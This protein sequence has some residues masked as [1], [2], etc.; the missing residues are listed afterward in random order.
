[1]VTEVGLED[2]LLAVV[3][4]QER[5]DLEK[6]RGTLLRQMNTMTIELQKC[7]DGLLYELTNATGD[8]LENVSLIENL[9]NTKKKAK[10]INIS[11]AQAVATQK[12]IAQSRLTYTPVAVR[13]SLLF[14]QIDQLWKIDHMYQYSLEAFM[15][16]FNKAL[17]KAV[18]PEDKK[19]VPKRVE[20][21]LR[22]IME[23]VFAYVSRGLFERHKLILSS[24]LTFAILQRQGTIDAHQLDFLLRGKKKTGILR[25][26][27][28]VEWC[29]EPNWAAVQA[30]ADVEGSVPPFN[31]LP[32]DIAENNRWRQWA[33][34]EKPE[35]EKMPSEW[36]NLTQFQRLLVLRCLRPDR[37]TAALETFVCDSIGRFFISDQ[38]VDI[39]VSIS[40]STT[41]TPLFFILSPGVDPVRAVEEAGRK[42]G[43]TYD[44]ERLF[45]VSLGQGQEIVADR[46]LERCFLHGG[47]ALLNNIHLVEKWLRGLE[48]RLDSYAEIYTRM[49]QLRKERD[50]KRAAELKLTEDAGVEREGDL[51]DGDEESTRGSL[52]GSNAGD[53][54]NEEKE[55]PAGDA[56]SHRSGDV[57]ENDDDDDIPF[58]GPKGHPQFRVFLSAEPSNVIPIG[59]LQRSIKLTSEPPTGIRSNIVR[60]MTNFSDEPWEKSAKPTEFRCIMFSMCF[61]HAV[62]VERKK[63]GP[64]G[65]NRVYPYNA[66]DLTTCLE[67]AANYIEDRPKVPWED[68]QYVFGEIMYGG[69]ITD[70]WDRVLCMAYLRTFLVPEC[71]DGLRLAPGL[72]V[73]APMSYNEYIDWLV[74]GEDFPA[75]SPLL[76]GL[77]PNAEINYRTV[78]ADVLFRTINELQPKKHAGA[79]SFSPQEV[80]QQKID[81]IRER[82][83]ER[84]NLQDLAER[85]EDERSPQQHVF[86]QECERMNILI[87]V[88]KV[89]LEELDLGLKG[90]LSMTTAMQTLFDEIFL[91]KLP[92]L[93][94][95]V[96]F[97]SLRTLG[98]WMENFL[99]R[100]D[101]LVTWT[102]ELQTPKVTNIALFFNPMSF[103]T[104][105]MQTTSI[106]NSFDLDQMSLVVDVLKKSADQIETN[107]RD[108]CH[109]S[110]LSME[111][112]RWDTG[113]SCIEESRM[114]ELYPKM[115]I[116]TVRSLPLSKIDRR[117]QYECPVYK[118]QQ[119]GPGFVVGFWLKTKQPAKKWTIAGVG[120]ILDV[121]E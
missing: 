98:S 42:L 15:V 52:N 116:M 112:A 79:G 47:W 90:A 120:L 115:P 57:E 58:D 111:G 89:S 100:N 23:T 39:S 83:P 93:W 18:Q 62:V 78:Q 99:L 113:T 114:K 4:N 70:D 28:V 80:V 118:T 49:A 12:D 97:L 82:L 51:G 61:F 76:F 66:G 101:Q 105:I 17:V 37:L 87:G 121:V 86:Y 20:N 64:L 88:L 85:L 21:V 95:K 92:A 110:G 81:E 30:L 53:G 38:A 119:R 72:D 69:H 1:M 31:L 33:E 45:N 6:K 75:E 43:F 74:N 22:S 65:W 26:E 94:E 102:G 104:A 8:I 60:A 19:D 48:R 50:E 68:L 107:A 9:E 96:S 27:T 41:T 63:F 54:T 106:V 40:E 84:H 67:V 34:T 77:H 103:L 32:G 108:G 5:P 11:F 59:I 13:G 10:E 36:K 44:N 56:A 16:V 73:P 24:L 55:E 71:C 14:F 25:P 109:V 7:E 2:Q 46:A 35:E 29:P 3:V 117:D 91:D